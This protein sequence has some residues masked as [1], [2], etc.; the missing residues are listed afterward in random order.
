MFDSRRVFDS[1][2]TFNVASASADG[3]PAVPAAGAI[4]YAGRK[5]DS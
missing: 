2:S 4:L 3:S 1:E 5:D